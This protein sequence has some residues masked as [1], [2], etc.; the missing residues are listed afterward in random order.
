MCIP[1]AEPTHGGKQHT[2]TVCSAEG[3][4]CQAV[5]E[6]LGWIFL[7]AEIYRGV[8]VVEAIFRQPPSN[9][10]LTQSTDELLW[11]FRGRRAAVLRLFAYALYPLSA[12]ACWP[13]LQ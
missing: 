11:L 10:P 6:K 4:Q 3:T 2:A 1:A 13:L 5:L 12:G 8:E 7:Q 9:A